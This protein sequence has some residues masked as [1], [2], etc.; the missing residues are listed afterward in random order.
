MQNF[1]KISLENVKV[2]FDLVFRKFIKQL[3]ASIVSIYAVCL[4]KGIVFTVF[5]VGRNPQINSNIEVSEDFC[6]C[7]VVCFKLF[8][9][10]ELC[11]HSTTTE[12]G[13]Q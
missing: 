10:L 4:P 2:F 6:I 9:E 5:H 13:I 3:D 8:F 1:L 12:F 7:F 11:K